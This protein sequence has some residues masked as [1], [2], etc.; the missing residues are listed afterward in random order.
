MLRAPLSYESAGRGSFLV[1]FFALVGLAVVASCS[2]SSAPPTG[3]ACAQASD[4][5]PGL[6]AGALSG[7]VTCLSLPGGYCS[8]TCTMDSDCCAVPGECPNG[9]KEVCAPL[10]SNA[11]LYCFVSCGAADIGTT[12]DGGTAD[13]TAY[14]QRNAGATF[15]CRSTGG[16][17]SNR[18]FCGP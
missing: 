18:K 7:Q 1:V 2:G 6:D 16:G 15:T 17:T 14:C 11:Q 5:Y 10:E 3:H 12:G 4:C 9:I 8:H 13:T